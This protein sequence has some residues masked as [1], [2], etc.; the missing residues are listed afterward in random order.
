MR[1]LLFSAFNFPLYGPDVLYGFVLN[2]FS[3]LTRMPGFCAFTQ[4]SADA[5][6][7]APHTYFLIKKPK[8]L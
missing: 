8:N 5:T 4:A 3:Y 2:K 1:I 7:I 6:M